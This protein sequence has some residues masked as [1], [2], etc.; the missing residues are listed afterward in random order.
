MAL[1]GAGAR[2]GRAPDVL[3]EGGGHVRCGRQPR[4]V[5]AAAMSGVGTAAGGARRCPGHR[6]EPSGA[7][8]RREARAVP[9]QTEAPPV[10]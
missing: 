2:S 3:G 10:N 1:H 5:K 7:C 8:G 9:V 4:W 6:R